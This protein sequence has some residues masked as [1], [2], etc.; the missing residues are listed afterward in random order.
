MSYF[1]NKK[2]LRRPFRNNRYNP[3]FLRGEKTNEMMLTSAAVCQ[4]TLTGR[5]EN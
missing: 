4:D 1:F 3:M 2:A 5:L